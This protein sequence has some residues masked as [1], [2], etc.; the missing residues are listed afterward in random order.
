MLA[1]TFTDGNLAA[2]DCSKYEQRLAY[3]FA[4]DTLRVLTINGIDVIWFNRDDEG[5]L[6]LNV[7]MLSV[8]P[9]ERALIEENFWR[10]IGQPTDLHSPPQGKELRIDYENGDHLFVKFL[11]I[12]SSE[13]AFEK[14]EHEA[15][16]KPNLI[17]FPITAVE[18]NYKIGGTGIEL[19]PS[20]THIQ[21]S[22]LKGGFVS[23]CGSGLDVDGD[24]IFR[25]NPSL[26]PYLPET[27]VKQCPCGSGIRYKNCHG[28]LS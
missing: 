16:R 28:L 12:N 20:G 5:Y 18:I 13:E 15:L 2:L 3:E 17:T 4:P 1:C 23:N 27:R 11:V 19:R 24:Y 14:Y 22:V 6:R 8:L 25:Q 7:K 10:N 26:L 21:S 9:K